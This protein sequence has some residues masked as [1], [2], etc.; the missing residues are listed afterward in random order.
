MSAGH[1]RSGSDRL[2]SGVNGSA[3]PV[4][5]GHCDMLNGSATGTMGALPWTALLATTQRACGGR[6]QY[7]PT[8]R[9]DRAGAC[10]G[11]GFV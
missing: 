2:G 11:D 7:L 4:V 10:F 8:P 1:T 9:R 5:G 3:C 6:Q